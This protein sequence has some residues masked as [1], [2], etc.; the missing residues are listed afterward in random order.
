MDFTKESSMNTKEI[1][2]QIFKDPGTKYELTEFEVLGKPLH[3]II[4]ICPKNA[5]TGRDP[6]KTK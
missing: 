2:D 5:A 4:S 3:E 6:G 1:I